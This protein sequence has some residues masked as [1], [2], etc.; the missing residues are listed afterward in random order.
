MVHADVQGPSPA[1]PTLEDPQAGLLG[2][3]EAPA[4]ALMDE[5]QSWVQVLAALCWATAVV[6]LMGLMLA[7]ALPVFRTLVT[8]LGD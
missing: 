3:T 8:A 6:G 7:G 2:P 1:Y 4:V 5:S